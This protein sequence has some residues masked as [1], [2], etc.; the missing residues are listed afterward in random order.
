MVRGAVVVAV[1]F[2]VPGS[3]DTPTGGYAYDRRV[4][5]ELATLGWQTEVVDLGDGFPRPSPRTR[6]AAHAL[7]ARTPSGQPIVID[8][9]AL[10][11]LP[12]AAAVLSARRPLVAL[13]HHP[14]ALETGLSADEAEA[15]HKSERSALAFVKH[16]IVSSPSTARILANDYGVAPDRVTVALPGTDPTTPALRDRD[17]RLALLAVGSLVPRKGYDV[18][19]AALATVVDLPWHLTIV[20]DRD[21]DP[22]TA[23]NLSTQIETLALEQRV[24]LVGAVPA[25]R[26]TEFYASSDVFVLAS[27]FE[28][29][30][31]A[32]A[33]AI[34]HGLPILGT[35]AGAIPETVPC[36]AGILVP[37]DDSVALAAAL[38]RL[39]TDPGERAR[40]AAG[41]QAAAAR[42]PTWQETANVF[43]RILAALA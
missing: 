13:V 14:L 34:A 1:S 26:L 33:Q 18:L 41:A 43:D 12:E 11:V 30:G 32:F 9:L 35:T 23:G 31:M 19:L 36:E 3:L 6:A 7:L 27:R 25:G 22:Q 2:A 15:F 21:R 5:A 24:S 39:A 16:S 37:P 29:Y 28:G 20:G 38:R 42:L 10:G 4:I 40:L 17:G 8:G